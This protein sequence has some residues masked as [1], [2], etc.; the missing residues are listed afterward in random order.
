MNDVKTSGATR[1]QAP[2]SEL[3]SVAQVAQRMDVTE[4]TV[5][6]W[7]KQER[8]RAQKLSGRWMV[9]EQDLAALRPDRQVTEI[10]EMTVT[11]AAEKIG[12]HTATI[13]MWIRDGLLD[14]RFDGRKYWV[15]GSV[16][17][18]LLDDKPR[19]GT[20]HRTDVDAQPLP[21][22]PLPARRR[23]RSD[24]RSLAT[25]ALA[26]LNRGSNG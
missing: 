5:R 16:L 3:L 7:L 11:Q 25:G 17:Q 10:G 14:A 15:R 9:Q 19:L 4:T 8:L 24:S 21:A 13:R 1:E 18:R 20:P 26:H 6:L 22:A 2:E 23:R 12:L